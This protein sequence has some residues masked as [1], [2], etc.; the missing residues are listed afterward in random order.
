[1]SARQAARRNT[2]VGEAVTVLEAGP[3][4]YNP[5]GTVPAARYGRLEQKHLSVE[6]AG[7][8]AEKKLRL[9]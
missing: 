1:M 9:V 6:E 2:S 3:Q 8:E 4:H 5:M 7:V